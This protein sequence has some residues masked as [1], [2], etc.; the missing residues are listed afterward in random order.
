MVVIYYI[1]SSG[2]TVEKVIKPYR[3]GSVLPPRRLI[4]RSIFD[5]KRTCVQIDC[6][7]YVYVQIYLNFCHAIFDFALLEVYILKIFSKAFI[8]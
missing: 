3:S 7:K 8:T 5:S 6:V 1:F 4:R 2:G